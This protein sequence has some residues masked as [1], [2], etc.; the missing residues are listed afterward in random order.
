MHSRCRRHGVNSLY[1]NSPYIVATSKPKKER[2]GGNRFHSVLFLDSNQTRRRRVV[3]CHTPSKGQVFT[4]T[5]IGP[6]TECGEIRYPRP[7]R[8]FSNGNFCG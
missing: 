1:P 5:N 2:A 4:A 3:G 6:V 7:A 8:L